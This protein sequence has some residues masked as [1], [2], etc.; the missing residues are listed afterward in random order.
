MIISNLDFKLKAANFL[1][2]VNNIQLT[3]HLIV[4]NHMVQIYLLLIRGI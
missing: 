3:L 4:Y 2:Q 1:I